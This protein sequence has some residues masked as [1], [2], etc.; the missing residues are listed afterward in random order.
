MQVGLH[1]LGVGSHF[2]YI[3]VLPQTRD[4]EGLQEVTAT[5]KQ[6]AQLYGDTRAGGKR[7]GHPQ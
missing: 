5:Q 3:T 7:Q 2:A 4:A 1:D 6:D